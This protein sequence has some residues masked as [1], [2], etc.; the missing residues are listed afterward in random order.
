MPWLICWTCR[1]RLEYHLDGSNLETIIDFL[2]NKHPNGAP[3]SLD[4]R[5]DRVHQVTKATD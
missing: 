4:Q 1:A 5:E 3:L 2:L